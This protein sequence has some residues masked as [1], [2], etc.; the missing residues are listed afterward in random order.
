[1]LDH[2]PSRLDEAL[3]KAGQRPAVNALR[4]QEPP[5]E[6][7]EEALARTTRPVVTSCD[8]STVSA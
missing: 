2:R 3:P 8:G 1:M 6:I 7:S 5:P 4:Q